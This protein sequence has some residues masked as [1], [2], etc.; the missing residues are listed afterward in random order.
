[1][2][3]VV[4]VGVL[5]VIYVATA[6]V[7]LSLDALHGFAA[8]V[9]PPTGIA[10]AALV[11]YGARLWPGIAV[12]AFLVNGLAGAPVLV[13]CGMALGNTLE[14]LVGAVLLTR[15]VGMRP[16]LDRLRDVLGLIGLAAGFST[17]LSA[18]LGVTSGWLD[19]VIPA[20]QYGMAW[21]TWWLGDAMG[22]LV[23]A[24]LFFVWSRRGLSAWPQRGLTEA[25][26]LLVAVGV[27]SFAVFGHIFDLTLIN[28][29][30]LVFPPLIWVAVRLGPQGAATAT[31]LVSASAIWGTVQGVGPFAGP[32]LH[33]SLFMLQAFMSVVAGT[34]LVLAA[35]TAERRRVQAAVHEQRERLHVTLTSIG[36]A[37]LVT[38]S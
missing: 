34:I 11:L 16:A 29:S 17:L 8:A 20:G 18:T 22:A 15:V 5:S 31:A 19:G 23:V 10:L 12:G 13:A 33:E 9:W 37:V 26:A 25:L 27:L 38:D 7:G 1:M 24:P 35:V 4:R 6:Q 3:V 30:Y 21:R 32:T 36:D 14:A 2:P 28:F